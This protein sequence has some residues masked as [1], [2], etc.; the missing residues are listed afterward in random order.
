LFNA[1]SLFFDLDC[2]LAG[3][4][5]GPCSGF[6]R[7]TGGMTDAFEHSGKSTGPYLRYRNLLGK[8][9]KPDERIEILAG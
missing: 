6:H 5:E 3:P 1:F 9:D 2:G 7:Y 4:L 8:D